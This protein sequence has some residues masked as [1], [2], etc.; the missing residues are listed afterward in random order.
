MFDLQIPTLYRMA[1]DDHGY[2]YPDS[3]NTTPP[4]TGNKPPKRP[5]TGRFIA[6]VAA[7]LAVTVLFLALAST[8]AYVALKGNPLQGRFALPT[9]PAILDPGDD[10]NLPAASPDPAETTSG[11]SDSD[12]AAPSTNKHFSISDAAGK[13]DP[14]RKALSIIEIARRGK[15]AVVAINTETVVSTPFGETG[16]L[17]AAG[18]GFIISADGYIVTNHHVIAGAQEISVVLDRGDTYT[19]HVVGLDSINDLAVLKIDGQNLPTVI[20]GESADLEVGELAV[21]IG[22]PLGELSGTVTAG[23]ISA[24]DR[25]VSVDGQTMALL[26]TDAAINAG[27]SGGA[28]FNSFGEVVGINSAKNT[29]TGIEGLGFAIPIDHAKPIIEDLIRN[30][31]ATGKPRI[32]LYTQDIT[33]DLAAQYDLPVGVYVAQ[34]DPGSP[35]DDAG[36]QKG[37][38][39]IAINGTEALTTEAINQIK[40]DYMPGDQIELTI[41]REGQKM[42]VVVILG[43]ATA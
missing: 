38:V 10:T 17:P 36:L 23:I 25:E 29:G 35:A 27:N 42:T 5:G 16:T 40:N 15:P 21:A 31:S 19:A 6:L 1:Q 30:G 7:F 3:P 33:E 43:E 22:N 9:S 34:V 18:S 2:V 4:P 12:L 41:V 8:I 37:D 26:Q 13:S 20:L 28:L 24:L 39:I 14:N 11:E 32:G